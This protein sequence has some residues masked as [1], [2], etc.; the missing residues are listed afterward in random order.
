[1][2]DQTIRI[3]IFL[4]PFFG[5]TQTITNQIT[6]GCNNPNTIEKKFS[7]LSSGLYYSAQADSLE[8]NDKLG[9]G[10]G[11]GDSWIAQLNDNLLIQNQWVFGGN[12][13]DV[14]SAIGE[15]S[16]G[17]LIIALSTF[18]DS[19]GTITT[20]KLPNETSYDAVVFR[21]T[22]SGQIV[23]ERRL[24]G[25]NSDVLDQLIVRGDTVFLAGNSN[26][27][28]SINKQSS[29]FG[30]QDYWLVVL[31]QNGQVLVDNN[32][33]GS[34][35]ETL[36]GMEL[37]GDKIYL[38]GRSNSSTS[39]NKTQTSINGSYDSWVLQLDLSGDL[40]QQQVFGGDLIESSSK[41][42]ALSNGNLV[43]AV[44]SNSG[45]SGNKTT[46]NIGNSDIWLLEVDGS[47][48]V[49]N[50]FSYG[51]QGE[52]R[53]KTLTSRHGVLYVSTYSNSGQNGNKTTIPKGQFDYW[54]LVLNED[55]TVV[56]QLGYG[57]TENDYLYG[58]YVLEP[59][60][61]VVCGSS[62]SNASG[63]KTTNTYNNKVTGWLITIEAPLGRNELTPSSTS[64]YP[65]P[66]NGSFRYISEQSMQNE[67]YTVVD[68]QGKIISQGAFENG[69]KN[70]IHVNA[71]PGIYYLNVRDHTPIKIVIE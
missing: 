51:G 31:D 61:L 65:N 32:Y 15:F 40:L 9:L 48:N 41:I 29:T 50:Q 60:K 44:E 66:C 70:S 12:Q 42:A 24:G 5:F 43:I 4:F 52:E 49:L 14:A 23:W 35:L 22:L 28:M 63:D 53:L 47:F 13:S 26:S 39:G 62:N 71:Q 56:E 37:Q 1:M 64:I 69:Y 45:V 46:S 6:I 59:G 33:G 55:F 27:D 19:S 10:Y 7:L 58:I 21:Y 67:S 17:D 68:Q 20:K 3:L 34:E 54:G 8:G 25:V 30:S 38:A 11:Q 57:G 18:S 36:T 16:N 2:K